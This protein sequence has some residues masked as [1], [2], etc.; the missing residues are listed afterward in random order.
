MQHFVVNIKPKKIEYPWSIKII[1]LSCLL[2]LAIGIVESLYLLTFSIF[3]PISLMLWV[4]TG[5]TATRY[6]KKLKENGQ[7]ENAS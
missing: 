1:A 3:I 5:I 2:S 6:Q 7:K 4:I